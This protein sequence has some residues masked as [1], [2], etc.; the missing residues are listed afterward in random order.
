MIPDMHILTSHLHYCN[1]LFFY[2]DD[3]QELCTRMNTAQIAIRKIA[4]RILQGGKHWKEWV[5]DVF[6]SF[7]VLLVLMLE[8]SGEQATETSSS[9]EIEECN[10]ARG[11]HCISSNAC[12]E[13]GTMC[14]HT[15][16]FEKAL[17]HLKPVRGG[18]R[19]PRVWSCTSFVN[20]FRSD[21][22]TVNTPSFTF[23]DTIAL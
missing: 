2:Y 8:P 16:E 6:F 20:E 14:V 4:N 18:T 19:V 1:D 7:T 21:W 3:W 17:W 22:Y 15:W 11:G 5:T 9:Q 10:W 13:L 12:L 23:P